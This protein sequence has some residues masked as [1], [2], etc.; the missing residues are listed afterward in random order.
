MPPLKTEAER[1]WGRAFAAALVVGL[2]ASAFAQAVPVRIVAANLT[3]GNH[4]TYSP[5]NGNHSNPEGAGARILRGLRPD[6]V[7]L[8][9]FNTTVPMRQWVNATFGPEFSFF[10]ESG[11]GI[12]NGIVSRW[13]IVES[14]EWDDVAMDNRDFAWAK[15]ALPGGRKL[16]AISVHWY[17]KK[18]AV[19]AE[20]ARAVAALVRERIPA[21]DLV[22]LGG[23]FN[24]R[25]SDEA[26]FAEV[27]PLFDVHAEP[28]ADAH[29]NVNTNSPR[30]RP[31]DWVLADAEL[32]ACAVPTRIGAASF[33]HGLVFDSRVFTSL[34]DVPPVQRGDSAAPQMQHMAVVRDFAVPA[35]SPATAR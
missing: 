12:P 28:P 24:T 14:G 21:E 25:G 10:V 32:A 15:I 23:D 30:N 3:S 34:A 11:A 17:S 13:P 4:Q 16:W 31:Y 29:G 7:L 22:V 20:Q 33:A 1:W 26:A 6:V 35:P 19:R 9:E 5:D 8:Q 2:A 27:A 18:A